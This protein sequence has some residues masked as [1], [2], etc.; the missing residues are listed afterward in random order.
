MKGCA[1]FA[2]NSEAKEKMLVFCWLNC[3]EE[4]VEGSSHC[5]RTGGGIDFHRDCETGWISGIL[6]S[7]IGKA[8]L[9]KLISVGSRIDEHRQ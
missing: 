6:Q 5:H 3:R 4:F 7:G 2:F 1:I 9:S 8:G